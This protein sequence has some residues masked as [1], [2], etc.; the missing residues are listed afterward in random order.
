MHVFDVVFCVS[1]VP[2]GSVYEPTE[3]GSGG[4]SGGGSGDA[5]VGGMGGGKIL[6]HNGKSLT[7]DGYVLLMAEAGSGG[8]A[9]GGSGGSVLIRTL[10]FSGFGIVDVS[11]GAGVG[12]GGGGAGGRV[13]VHIGFANK[14]SGRLRTV[15]G[16]SQGSTPGGAAGTVYVE[17]SNRGPQYADIKYDVHLNRTGVVAQHRRL[18]VDNEDLDADLYVDHAEPWLYTVISEGAEDEYEFDE[19]LLHRHANMLIGYPTNSD[20]V[21]IWIHKFYGDRTGMVH[22]RDKQHLYVEYQVSVANET[23]PP[24]SFRVDSGAEIIFPEIVDL[25]GTRTWLAGLITGVQ[26]LYITGGADVVFLSTAQTA[27]LEN[28][29]YS[30]LT[31]PG[32]FMFSELV[33]ERHSMAEFNQI[34]HEMVINSSLLRVMYQGELF[35]NEADIFTTYAIVES[36]GVFH[37]DGAGY[38]AEDGPGKGSTL[39]SG[40]GVGAGYGGQG[41]GP[42][43]EYGGRPYGSVYSPVEKGS[44]GGNGGGVGGAGGGLLYWEVADMLEMNGI[45]SLRGANGSGTHSSGGTGGGVLIK[46]INITGH[47]LIRVDGGDGHDAGGGGAGGRVGIHCRWRYAYGGQFDNYG[48]AGGDDHGNYHHGAAGTTYKEENFRELEYRH[49]K[50]DKVHNTTFLAVDHMYVHS[51]NIYRYSPAATLLMDY[52]RKDYEFDEMELSGTS[53]L[54]LYHPDNVTVVTLVVHKFIGDRTGQL[55]LRVNQIAHVEVVE[56]ESNR[57]EA[58][59]SYIVDIGAEIVLPTEFHVHGTNSSVAGRI[60]GVKHLFIEDE[61]VLDLYSTAQTALVENGTYTML[62]EPGNFTWDTVSVKRGGTVGFSRNTDM[63]HLQVSKISVK[64]QGTLHMNHAEIKCSYAWVESEGVFHLDGKGHSAETGPGAGITDHSVGWG[65]GHGGYGSSED[66]SNAAHPYGS[67]YTPHEFGSGGGNGQG[68]GGSGGG[69][70]AWYVGH[71]IE[72]N[73][74]LSG[75][76]MDGQGSDAGGG[77]GGSIMISST[78]LTGHGEISVRGGHG[79]GFGGGGAGGRIGVHCRWRYSFGGKFTDCGGS[80]TGSN[81]LSRG[82]AAGTAFIENNLRPLQYRVLKYRE[83]TN[84]TY[85]QVDHRYVHVDNE[86][87]LVPVPTMI[88][89]ELETNYTFDEMEL[90]GHSRL[91]FYHPTGSNVTIT[92]HRF[93]GDKTGRVHIQTD[94][95]LFSEVVESVRNVTEAPCSYIIDYGAE[96][97]LPSEVRFHGTNTDLMGLITGIHHMYIIAGAHV[98]VYSTSQTALQEN[99]QYTHITQEGNFSLPTINIHQTAVLSFEKVLQDLT[100]TAAS[101]EI[102][103]QGTMLMNHGF[104]EVGEA[105]LEAEAVI[106]LNAM[107]HGAGQGSGAGVGSS[108]GSYG[109][110]GGGNQSGV[111]YGSVYTP[112]DLGSG[113]GG[114]SGG[115]GGGRIRLRVGRML[116]IDGVMSAKGGAATDGHSGGGSGGTILVESYKMSGHGELDVSGGAGHG[117]GGGGSGGRL[118]AHI[119]FNNIYGGKYTG[120]GGVSGTNDKT[121]LD[122][123]GPGT[124]Y[125]YE[126]N[127]GPQYRELKY[128]PRLNQTT[129]NPEHSKLLVDSA[130]LDTDNP[131]MVMEDLTVFYDLHEVQVEG[132]AYVEFYHPNTGE[133]VNIV[134]QELTGNKKGLIR[135]RDR[136]RMVVHFVESTHTHLDAPCGLHVDQGAEVVL[137]TVVTITAEL[138]ILEGQ[139]TG[140]EELYIEEDGEFIC[141]GTCHTHTAPEHPMWYNTDLSTAYSPA[142]LLLQTVE[143]TSRGRLTMRN[144]PDTGV[145]IAGDI[146]VLANGQIHCDSL[147]TVLEASNITVEKTGVVTGSGYGYAQEEGPGRGYSSAYEGSGGAHASQG[148]L[149]MSCNIC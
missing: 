86:G 141:K 144:N 108:G 61:A 116:H 55:H 87:L 119:T 32:N 142:M 90:T 16:G 7:I 50:Y 88:L 4:G 91:V 19:A 98:T 35:M 85:F 118:A 103:Y 15:G 13:A 114:T 45:L 66:T 68:G 48:G 81:T 78:N 63:M 23:M 74:L 56:S 117:I 70:L 64:Y 5:G 10:N 18:E 69:I 130:D 148:K 100:V 38:G 24:C 76:G 37:M 65:A 52:D 147:T 42:G 94:Q 22:I 105:D 139:L 51:D 92:V 34:H 101:L 1:G 44:G 136:Q 145:L 138:F 79:S 9:G 27:L 43:P 84:N 95:M 36:Q 143:V 129:V 62:T 80:G 124:V 96:L 21:T 12:D 58:P 49:K 60:T 75:S 97:L 59:C 107:G 41:G 26:D 134:I 89:E 30:K 149:E 3:E 14:F 99:R 67:V 73:G 133:S 53:R 72:L 140:V 25:I 54:L 57:T 120:H 82:A 125:K 33:V 113:G 137:P 6:W 83:G 11:G 123:G 39:S 111:P 110:V 8:N 121:G 106:S 29:Q 126:S 128:N 115:G 47:G 127:R 31:D 135:V 122:V 40:V 102:K 28:G 93:I 71:R 2:Y 20:H 146:R 104:V 131:A 17:E 46:T 112:V 132:Y 77:S 109:G